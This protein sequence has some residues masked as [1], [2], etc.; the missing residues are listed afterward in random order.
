MTLFL[1]LGGQRQAHLCEVKN[2]LLYRITSK[3]SKLH[4]ESLSWKTSNYSSNNNNNNNKN[5][6]VIFTHT[7]SVFIKN[8]LDILCVGHSYNSLKLISYCVE[9]S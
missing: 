1:A 9:D 6:K 7:L 2:S 4:E 3:I 8:I 5:K